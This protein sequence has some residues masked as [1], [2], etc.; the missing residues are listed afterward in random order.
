MIIAILIIII[1]IGMIIL[2]NDKVHE[3]DD[4]MNKL[5]RDIKYYKEENKNLMIVI[6][7]LDKQIEELKKEGKI[8]C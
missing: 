1:L 5:G 8:K 4:Y 6:E 2:L 3:N 7:E